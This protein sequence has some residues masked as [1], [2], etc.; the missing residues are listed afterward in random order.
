MDDHHD[1]HQS[2]ESYGSFIVLGATGGIGRAVCDELHRRG[3][4]MVLAARRAEPLRQLADDLGARAMVTDA[5]DFTSVGEL[6]DAT[7]S[8][9]RRIAG[10]VNCV[11]S[12]ML[13][14]AHLT[15]VDDWA[16]TIE[17]NLTSAFAVVRSAGQ[18]MK[19]GGSVVLL[20]SAAARVGMPNHEAIAAAK[21]GVEG[22]VLAAAASY[23]PRNLRVNAVAPGLVR[24][25]LTERITSSDRALETSRA[26]HPIGRIGE[27]TDI[28]TAIMWLLN[29]A[30]SWITGQIVG[31]DG[32]LATVRTRVAS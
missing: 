11:G 15:S 16:S 17:K 22:L 31:V 18:F 6:F 28:A 7:Q 8:D 19:D 9:D 26:M 24:T 20:S 12:I 3:A 21:A 4:P 30:S 25:P 32:G 29:P 2:L 5:T 10:V 1:G 23:A 27:P 14:P 13:K